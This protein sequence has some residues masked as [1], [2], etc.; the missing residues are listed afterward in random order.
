MGW[1]CCDGTYYVLLFISWCFCCVSIYE[2]CVWL[3]SCWTLSC[4]A[5]TEARADPAK[6]RRHSLYV[7][8]GGSLNA[9]LK[10]VLSVLCIYSLGLVLRIFF[11]WGTESRRRRP[12][13]SS[14][15]IILSQPQLSAAAWPVAF[16]PND[17]QL[18]GCGL[19]WTGVLFACLLLAWKNCAVG[20]R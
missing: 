8:G 13:C 5:R 3:A 11:G 10:S 19:W 4:N 9:K 2:C 7:G 15:S 6:P 12:R 17:E 20:V 16:L 18:L 1:V 14:S